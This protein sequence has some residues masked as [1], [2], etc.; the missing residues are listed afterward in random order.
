MS[1]PKNLPC[2]WKLKVCQY[3]FAGWRLSSVTLSAGRARGRSGGRHCTVGQYGYVPL[4]WHLVIIIVV[5]IV[6][7]AARLQL[8]VAFI[9][10]R[11]LAVFTRSAITLP[12]VNRFGWNL[13]HSEYIVGDWSAWSWQILRTIRAIS[14][15]GEPGAIFCQVRVYD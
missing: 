6:R 10:R 13:E 5:I 14:I 12:K 15:A 4:G 8:N 2:P 3:C 1:S 11:V 7:L 9:L